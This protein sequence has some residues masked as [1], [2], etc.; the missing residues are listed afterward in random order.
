MKSI[1]RLFA[2][3]CKL[4][5]QIK[6]RE[7]H[8]SLQQDLKNLET[9]AKTLG[10]RSNAKKYYTMSINSK[11]THFYQ[12]DSHILQQ[13]PENPFLCVTISDDFEAVLTYLQNY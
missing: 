8:I 5:W 3:D 6:S 1:V 2:D 13:V 12:L 9:W 7:Y 10:M 4:Y 11:S